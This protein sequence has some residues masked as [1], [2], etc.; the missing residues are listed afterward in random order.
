MAHV[1]HPL[2]LP[3]PTTLNQDTPQKRPEPG[4]SQVLKRNLCPNTIIPKISLITGTLKGAL[5]TC[6]PLPGP[7]PS[8]PLHLNL[9]H[10]IPG[11]SYLS[12][13]PALSLST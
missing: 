6:P 12:P 5:L 13:T 10:S 7:Q 1:P 8:Q 2:T 9:E 11:P 4:F 3:L